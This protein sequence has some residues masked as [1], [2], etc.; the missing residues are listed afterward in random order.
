MDKNLQPNETKTNNVKTIKNVFIETSSLIKNTPHLLI[1]PGVIATFLYIFLD[2]HFFPQNLSIGDTVLFIFITLGFGLIS[3]SIYLLFLGVAAPFLLKQD[4]KF[5]E[6]AHSKILFIPT[7][8]ITRQKN[9]DDR[10][11]TET[12]A[13]KISPNF[14]SKK[15]L[16]S[17]AQYF[18]KHRAITLLCCCILL[19]LVYAATQFCNIHALTFIFASLAALLPLYPIVYQK[20]LKSVKFKNDKSTAHIFTKFWSINSLLLF[21]IINYISSILITNKGYDE[22]V[23][24]FLSFFTLFGSAFFLIKIIQNEIVIESKITLLFFFLITFIAP[25]FFYTK[26]TGSNPLHISF[27]LLGIRHNKA[28]L[29]LEQEAYKKIQILS[30]TADL[31]L[32]TCPSQSVSDKTTLS[33]MQPYNFRHEKHILKNATLL[34]HGLG[35]TSYLELTLAVKPDVL[36]KHKLTQ[37]KEKEKENPT[38]NKQNNSPEFYSLRIELP[39]DSYTLAKKYQPKQ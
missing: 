31:Q 11:R 7:S 9:Y 25:L 8:S 21:F 10:K 39:K 14:L 2:I 15:H 12:D 1:A 24:F 28:T 32:K 30:D 29:L 34:W 33:C 23:L 19:L 36:N 38:N 18:W 6:Q 4:K 37:E 27:Q 16:D 26:I 13:D 20:F 17:V 22:L 3:I 5:R 35:Q